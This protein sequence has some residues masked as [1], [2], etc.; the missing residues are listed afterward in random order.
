MYKVGTRAVKINTHCFLITIVTKLR[1]Q[2]IHAT[3]SARLQPDSLA[4]LNNIWA[5]IR[6]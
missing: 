2:V 1:I 3:N 5:Y 6:G 4:V